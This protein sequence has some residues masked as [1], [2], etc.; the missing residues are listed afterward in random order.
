MEKTVALDL[1]FNENLLIFSA[2]ATGPIS[3]ALEQSCELSK[4][5]RRKACLSLYIYRCVD[6][7]MG[8]Q[9]VRKML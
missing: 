2:A 6:F 1:N 8:I 7:S 5:I 9:V 3:S 4:L